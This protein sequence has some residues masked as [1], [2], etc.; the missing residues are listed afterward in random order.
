MRIRSDYEISRF[1]DL[2][3]LTMFG[4]NKSPKLYY[5][6]IRFASIRNYLKYEFTYK[7]KITIWGIQ[8]RDFK[9]IQDLRILASKMLLDKGQDKEQDKDLRNPDKGLQKQ[10]EESEISCPRDMKTSR[11]HLWR[12]RRKSDWLACDQSTL[13]LI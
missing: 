10:L 11:S 1:V 8:T 4:Y 7:I 5:C 13:K 3:D 6:K 2:E 9:R 12:K